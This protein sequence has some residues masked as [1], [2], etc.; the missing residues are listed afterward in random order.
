MFG[1]IGDDSLVFPTKLLLYSLF[2]CYCMMDIYFSEVK[3]TTNS[4]NNELQ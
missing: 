4:F 2:I 1:V 3:N